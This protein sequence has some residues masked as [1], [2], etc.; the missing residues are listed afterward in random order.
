MRKKILLTFILGTRPEIIKLSPL[1]RLC[2]KR[3]IPFNIIHSGQH[4]SYDMDRVFFKELGLPKPDYRLDIRSRAPYLQGEHT[5]RMLI[6]IERILLKDMPRAVIVQGDTNTVLAGAMTAEKISTTKSYTGFDIK[7][8]HVEAGLRSFDRTMPEEINRFIVDHIS[9]FLFVPTAVE[10]C[11]VLKEGVPEGNI[12]ITGNTIVDAVSAN[13]KLARQKNNILNVHKIKKNNY[14]LLTLHRQENVDSKERFSSIVRGIKLVAETLRM[15]VI[16]PA[17]PRT[18]KK[19]ERFKL[20]FGRNVSVLAPVD[21]LSFLNLEACA[22]LI[23]TDSGGVQEEACILKV[24][25][26]TLRENTERPETV[27][28]G[29]NMLGGI[30]PGTIL[31]ASL[32]MADKRGG[33]A[34]PFGDGHAAEKMLSV[35]LKNL[36]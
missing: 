3:R 1:I 14:I 13:L 18:V 26:V 30:K 12:Y 17:H 9:D 5:G 27:K 33:W 35:L 32:K 22:S 10:K 36:R 6:E 16:F 23:L 11:L 7:V 20:R 4:Y 24:P 2:Q 29:S 34:N 15:P 25:C 31:K 21:F 28:V 19:M 8:A